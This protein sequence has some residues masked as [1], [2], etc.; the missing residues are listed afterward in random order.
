MTFEIGKPAAICGGEFNGRGLITPLALGREPSRTLSPAF[1]SITRPAT[2]R[3]TQAGYSSQRQGSDPR[4][5]WFAWHPVYIVDRWYWLTYV[6]RDQ[7]ANK[8]ALYRYGRYVKA[9]PTTGK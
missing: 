5:R 9:N 6:A 3:R 1:P 2:L 7:Y 8:P 4:Q